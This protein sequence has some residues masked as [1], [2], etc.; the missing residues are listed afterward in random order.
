MIS[1]CD[2]RSGVAMKMLIVAA[3]TALVVSGGDV[4]LAQSAILR[5]STGQIAG[6][7]ISDTMMLVVVRP[8]VIAPALI[9][10]VVDADGRVASGLATWAAGGSVLFTSDDCTSGAHVYS[11]S[12]AGVRA[13]SQL[14]TATGTT[15]YVGAIGNT[16]TVPVR[17]I[18]YSS[19][20]APVALQQS[21]LVPVD[22]IVN[23]TTT[24]P[25]PLSIQ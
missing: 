15:L 21:G 6:R 20:C 3:T 2:D 8:G 13:T 7:P 11:T 16:R 1:A 4:A 19:G 22:A 10:P 23:L 24:Y 18:L 25:P 12:H 14:E 9:R 5:D 17:S